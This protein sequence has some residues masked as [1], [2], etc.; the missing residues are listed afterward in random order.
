[1]EVGGGGRV[2]GCER[3]LLC[4]SFDTSAMLLEAL[5]LLCAS[6]FLVT[7]ARRATQSR[8]PSVSKGSTNAS[9]PDSP[10]SPPSRDEEVRTQTD[11][12]TKQV[13]LTSSDPPSTSNLHPIE[14]EDQK[15]TPPES[16]S[17]P[18][19]V[20]PPPAPL[21]LSFVTPQFP[22]RDGTTSPPPFVHLQLNLT[23]RDPDPPLV[24][25]S[26]PLPPPA[27]I[28]SPSPVPPVHPSLS[29]A[30]S[31]HLIQ[32]YPP[33]KLSTSLR[34]SADKFMGREQVT[35]ANSFPAST[36]PPVTPS[37]TLPSAP[38]PILLP[39]VTPSS[40]L[41]S[42]VSKLSGV[43]RPMGTGYANVSKFQSSDM[44][45][46]AYGQ[47]YGEPQPVRSSASFNVSPWG[48][49]DDDSSD[50]D[51]DAAL[52]PL[53]TTL[54]RSDSGMHRPRLKGSLGRSSRKNSGAY[55][56]DSCRQP[57]PP[58][59]SEGEPH[60][61]NEEETATEVPHEG[62]PNTGYPIDWNGHFQELLLLPEGSQTEKERKFQRISSLSKDFLHIAITFG[63]IIISE[64]YLPNRFKTIKPVSNLGGQAGGEKYVYHG[65]LFKFACD[66]LGFYGGDENAM[67]AGGHELKGLMRY[68]SH[69]GIHVPLMA[70]VDYRGFRLV[71]MSILPI[72]ADSIV[73]G[74]CDGGQTVHAPRPEVNE[75]M[76]AAAKKMNIKGHM[77]GM[78]QQREFLYAPTDIEGHIGRDGLFYVLDLARTFPPTAEDDRVEREFLYKLFRPEFV[79]KYRVPL[80]SDSFSP[81]GGK[82]NLTV[83]NTEAREATEYLLRTVIPGF[84][85]WLEGK[86]PQLDLQAQLTELLHRW[87]IN[88]RYLGLVRSRVT[89]TPLRNALLLEMVARVIKN[90]LRQE[91]RRKMRE[92]RTLEEESFIKVVLSF[93]N[94]VLGHHPTRSAK[95]WEQGLK[96]NLQKRFREG[97]SPVEAEGVVPIQPQLDMFLLFKRIQAMTGIAMTEQSMMELRSDPTEFKM[98]VPDITNMD[99]QVKH[100]NLVSLFEGNALALQCLHLTTN[101]GHVQRTLS[102]NSSSNTEGTTR[103]SQR[104][105]RL[106]TDKFE[107]AIRATPD[108]IAILNNY[109]DVLEKLA[110][111]SGGADCMKYLDRALANYKLA[112]NCLAIL[113]LGNTLLDYAQDPAPVV[114]IS[115]ST[116]QSLKTLSARCFESVA[117]WNPPDVV[118]Q[119]LRISLAG[120]DLKA[121]KQEAYVN[122]GKLLITMAKG[123]CDDA[124]YAQ[125]GQKI[126]C[127]LELGPLTALASSS[128]TAPTSRSLHASVASSPSSSFS[129]HLSVSGSA[130]ASFSSTSLFSSPFAVSALTRLAPQLHDTQLAQ[131][132][133]ILIQSPTL[134]RISCRRLRRR[135]VL[136]T[137]ELLNLIWQLH[138]EAPRDND[139]DH[140]TFSTEG[141]SS[142]F[143]ILL[144]HC[145]GLSG[146]GLS[147]LIES[148]HAAAK[149]RR[150]SLAGCPGVGGP[151]LLALCSLVRGVTSVDLSSN[152]STVTNSLVATLLL[153]C[154]DL[155]ELRVAGCIGVSDAAFSKAAEVRSATL[156]NLFA[157]SEDIPTTDATVTTLPLQ[158]LDVS[159]T[160]VLRIGS[161]IGCRCPHLRKVML[162]M[163]S[164]TDVEVATLAQKCTSLAHVDL[165]GCKHIA[166]EGV[167]SL[168]QHRA[169][170]LEYLDVSGCTRL[171]EK[172]M[173][174][175]EWRARAIQTLIISRCSAIG[176][177]PRNS[178]PGSGLRLSHPELSPGGVMLRRFDKMR[179]IEVLH[180]CGTGFSDRAMTDLATIAHH[181]RVLHVSGCRGIGVGA[182][183]AGGMTT[184]ID[185]VAEHC[186]QLEDVDFS[187][188]MISDKTLGHLAACCTGLRRVVVANCHRVGNEG[189]VRLAQ[190]LA[191][192][193]RLNLTG[194]KAISDQAV[195][196]IAARCPRLRRLML[197]GCSLITDASVRSIAAH[198]HNLRHLDFNGCLLVTHLHDLETGA[199][200]LKSLNLHRCENVSDFSVQRIAH[201]AQLE[202][203]NLGLVK[204]VSDEALRHIQEAAPSLMDLILGGNKTTDSAI[205]HLRNLRPDIH[206]TSRMATP[207]PSPQAIS[208]AVRCLMAD[209]KHIQANPLP[210]ISAHPLEDSLFVWHANLIGPE[211]TPYAG[212]LFHI[213]LA[214]PET[215]PSTS[216]SGSIFT[217]LPHPHV[218][219]GGRICLDLLSDFQSYFQAA[220]PA[221]S[222]HSSNSGLL[223]SSAEHGPI[224]TS[225]GAGA[226]GWSSAYSVQTILLQILTF[227]MDVE[228]EDGQSL[229]SFLAK[230]PNAIIKSLQFSCSKCPHQPG[231]PWPPLPTDPVSLSALAL[232][233][234]LSDLGDLDAFESMDSS[235]DDIPSRRLAT[236][237][238]SFFS[239]GEQARTDMRDIRRSVGSLGSGSPESAP[240]H[241]ALDRSMKKNNKQANAL[242]PSSGPTGSDDDHQG[243]SPEVRLI[244]QQLVCYH[245]R[246][247][248]AEDVLG[249]GVNVVRRGK[250]IKELETPL[251]LLSHTAFQQQNVRESVLKETF[252]HWLPLY[253]NA[254]HG[255]RAFPLAKRYV[256]MLCTRRDNQ[257]EPH[258]A[259]S[260]LCKLM[261]TMVVNLMS[262]KLYAS[263]RALEG[264]SFFH[265]LLLMFVDKCPELVKY[266]EDQ[267]GEFIN[268]PKKRTKR[269]VPALGEFLPLLSVSR[270]SWEDIA[271]AYFEESWDRNVYWYLEKFHELDVPEDGL[272]RLSDQDRCAKSFIGARVSTRLLMFHVYFLRHVARPPSATLGMVAARYD[273]RYGYPSQDM[274]DDLQNTVRE[275]LRVS[276][277]REVFARLQMVVPSEAEI[278]ERLRASVR[279]S[280]EKGYHGRGRNNNGHAPPG[281]SGY[282]RAGSDV[283]VSGG[284]AELRGRRGTNAPL[285]SSAS[286][287][288]TPSSHPSLPPSSY[289][290][291]SSHPRVPPRPNVSSPTHPAP[292]SN[293]WTKPLL[294][295]PPARTIS[296]TPPPEPTRSPPPPSEGE[297]TRD[298]AM[299]P[300]RGSPPPSGVHSR[301]LRRPVSSHLRPDAPVYEPMGGP[302]PSTPP[303]SHHPAVPYNAYQAYP[304]AYVP[305]TPH[306]FSPVFPAYVP[307]PAP[308]GVPYHY[309]P[310]PLGPDPAPYDPYLPDDTNYDTDPSEQDD[311]PYL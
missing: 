277:W 45:T 78:G 122:W 31:T 133:E 294:P 84:A 164:V 20:T 260:V 17:P 259:M 143:D 170:T 152:S 37:T 279:R 224:N 137:S 144:S 81:F 79:Q 179:N 168:V 43:M 221:S 38:P 276:S 311:Y 46:L 159:G 21:R 72:G 204:R 14:E 128:T 273:A 182:E 304:A 3:D 39:S 68:C 126:R 149:V 32:T 183:G 240:I 139:H 299:E 235:S 145:H 289:S 50:G 247:P 104:L 248:F 101:A 94:V 171:T 169:S 34:Q 297:D 24:S 291:S 40:V 173:E 27:G 96:V 309:S 201:L 147:R 180:A 202:S 209:L 264:Y 11:T 90:L 60:D 174:R 141:R 239:E 148:P 295:T 230:I 213:E 2:G 270:F 308:Y 10:P 238:G 140:E 57:A 26:V 229:E 196:A 130:L 233:P 262:E 69:E 300:A 269:S 278:A 236:S 287:S 61:L 211:G 109:A 162:G 110:L 6:L 55:Y 25:P 15:D 186:S 302:G 271:S 163:T 188:T 42:S 22:P 117:D 234:R 222:S 161:V 63:K 310:Y 18:A 47:P 242:V 215:F 71:A 136:L 155:T 76:K 106:A 98:V 266:A 200:S 74:S 102:S 87:G 62:S 56:G 265:R 267:I 123:M 49:Q 225:G 12:D 290:S 120:H 70:L 226:V 282:S 263:Q 251:D 223:R 190:S 33:P 1:M 193:E 118:G 231:S 91:L 73:Y 210:L 197:G 296:T 113:R 44:Y 306:V 283:R 203:L 281:P 227:L 80:S 53:R 23:P 184:G 19:Q 275:I 107:D 165:S 252:T 4:A 293:A 59:A 199:P 160:Q 258:M 167:V 195:C 194:C 86:Y 112:Q 176:D 83:H 220:A 28:A 142:E 284:R 288:S 303:H 114:P 93:L 75:R 30:R 127:A 292:S 243:E 172:A 219:Q 177:V 268:D 65:V 100:M 108:N 105:F 185:V 272:D 192:L 249:I 58:G 48:G 285:P 103:G 134:A 254:E 138:E 85:K 115:H 232:A 67:K 207:A 125:A 198:L 99:V 151:M 218:H 175:L 187:D 88:A 95:F 256:S 77:C 41:R 181:L 52:S 158:A 157:E 135:G 5:L 208:Q 89:A 241:D 35:R 257:F 237:T 150:L 121:V 217:P 178:N 305:L 16:T 156:D 51:D 280:G 286:S 307:S 131:L 29:N 124:M 153:Q 205:S 246:V 274:K 253:I 166:D 116:V 189:M 244:R 7:V 191:N 214:F 36:M 129:S 64:A 146:E 228:E 66:W 119:T 154:A 212:G 82:E 216:P 250:E 97:L 245:T 255:M 301:P 9:D 261:N 111:R 8:H 92:L 206:V 54:N 132:W 13:S 298:A